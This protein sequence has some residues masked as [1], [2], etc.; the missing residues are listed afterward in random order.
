MWG[1]LVTWLYKKHAE[2]TMKKAQQINKKRKDTEREQV[3]EQMKQLYG[4]V[5]FLN[6]HFKN[7]HERKTFWKSV[8][9]DEPVMEQ[10]IQRLIK[11]MK[12]K[13]QKNERT[14]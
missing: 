4:F 10:T 14:A 13:G 9:G 11:R 12:E 2:K 7:R 6:K 5:I 8:A 3:L 1:K